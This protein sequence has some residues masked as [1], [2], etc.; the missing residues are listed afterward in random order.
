MVESLNRFSDM[1]TDMKS[2][3]P[4][5]R[6][7]AAEQLTLLSPLMQQL[8]LERNNGGVHYAARDFKSL[9]M[10]C[11]ILEISHNSKDLWNRPDIDNS[12]SATLSPDADSVIHRLQI[13]EYHTI[14]N[15]EGFL[16]PEA[17]VNFQRGNKYITGRADWLLCH[18]DSRPG[19]DSKFIA[20]EAKRTAPDCRAKV[21]KIHAVAFGITTDTKI[22]TWIDKMLADAIEASPL[23]TP[24]LRRN[25]SLRNW[26]KNLRRRQLLSSAPEDSP[27]TEGLPFDISAPESSQL[28]GVAWYYGRQVMVVEYEEEN[29]ED[30]EDF[31]VED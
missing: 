27:L 22:I 25:V 11:T 12:P 20:I 10:T 9:V 23:T 14:D 8:A 5:V 26:E 13:S 29:E 2:D 18:D 30:E 4:V 1:L 15:S 16:Y 21:S 19:I 17:D 3:D 6:S 7:R 31:A 28:I 24:T